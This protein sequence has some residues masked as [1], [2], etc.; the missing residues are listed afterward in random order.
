MLL[1]IVDLVAKFCCFTA[2][3]P[4]SLM[5][6]YA[7]VTKERGQNIGLE[8]YLVINMVFG[9]LHIGHYQKTYFLLLLNIFLRL[10][11]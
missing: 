6:L 10:D 5:F 4:L 11:T 7:V 1:K 9:I 2:L 8:R 3:L